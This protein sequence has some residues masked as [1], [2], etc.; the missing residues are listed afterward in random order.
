MFGGTGLGYAIANADE[1]GGFD[2]E[3]NIRYEHNFPPLLEIEACLFGTDLERY[4]QR[5]SSGQTY[6]NDNLL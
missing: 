1:R 5:Q 6:L 3:R 2:S 4:V